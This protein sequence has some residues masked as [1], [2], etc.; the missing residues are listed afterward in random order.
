MTST[1]VLPCE[2]QEENIIMAAVASINASSSGTPPVG[3][4]KKISQPGWWRRPRLVAGIVVMVAVLSV[5]G[6]IFA[7]AQGNRQRVDSSALTFSVVT[8]GIFE[9]YVPVRG[10]VTPLLTVYLD[11]LEGGRVEKLLVEDGTIVRKGQMLAVLSNSQLQLEV[12]RSESEVTQQ[13]NT[14]RSI[15]LSL[16]QNALGHKRTLAE[17]DW[18]VARLGRQVAREKVL[19]SEG[20]VATSKFNDSQ[21]EFEYNKARRD[22]TLQSQRSDQ[23]L[24]GA[25]LGQMRTATFQLQ[26]NLRLARA[27]LDGLNVRAPVDGQLTAFTLQIGQ[28]LG[29]GERLGQLDSPGQTKLQADIDEFYLNRV[30][31]GQAAVF[32]Q[33]GKTYAMTLTKIYP[34]VKNGNFQ[35]DLGFAGT[36]PSGLR[37]GQTLDAKLTLSDPAKAQLIPNGSFYADTGGAWVFVVSSTGDRAVKRQVKLGRRNAGSIEVLDGLQDG[38]RIIT[39][40]YTAFLDRDRLDL[41]AN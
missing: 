37:R 7:G 31:V 21:S 29:R 1:A 30:S 24:Q 16:E 38:E 28:S 32:E 8:R 5:A 12:I 11:A 6:V 40:P 14:L 13:L 15:E 4:D 3:M 39:S 9:D 41:S 2:Q 23:R 22:V 26:Q 36:E 10:K 35:V 18:A 17:I 34:N 19:E 33:D 20:W 27:N 25:Q